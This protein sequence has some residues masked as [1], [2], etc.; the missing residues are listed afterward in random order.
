MVNGARA[1]TKQLVIDVI[2]QEQMSQNGWSEILHQYGRMIG[3]NPQEYMIYI[4]TQS[5]YHVFH[6]D[7]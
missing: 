6:Y 7:V 2:V 1:S 4:S 5:K 3:F